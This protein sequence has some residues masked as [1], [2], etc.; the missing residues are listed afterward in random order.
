[1]LPC[2]IFDEAP[3]TATGEY[4]RHLVVRLQLG[5]TIGP[6]SLTKLV[7]ICNSGELCEKHENKCW[8]PS[9]MQAFPR[10]T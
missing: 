2:G 9:R 8:R 4:D 7:L 10:K 1:M 5:R 3:N 6:Q